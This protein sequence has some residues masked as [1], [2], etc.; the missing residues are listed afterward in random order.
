MSSTSS[1]GNSTSSAYR[2]VIGGG[3]KLKGGITL[4]AKRASSASATPAASTSRPDAAS[5]A[6]KVAGVGA[7]FKVKSESR[8]ETDPAK[9][10][11]KAD[12]DAVA[13]VSDKT[14]GIEPSSSSALPAPPVLLAS[15]N[16]KAARSS[17]GLHKEEL[18]ELDAHLAELRERDRQIDRLDPDKKREMIEREKK[19]A[20]QQVANMVKS[21]PPGVHFSIPSSAALNKKSY[22]SAA[23]AISQS[24]DPTSASARLEARAKKKADRY[25][26]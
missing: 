21:L 11:T 1:G 22:T 4:K 2:K 26:K 20:E 23:T 6:L 24:S 25:C 14:N 8:R 10:G 13:T 5:K 3:L 19:M 9:L 16:G 17:W 12:P 7:G 15:T 18:H